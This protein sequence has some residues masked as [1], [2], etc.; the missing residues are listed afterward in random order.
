MKR[1]PSCAAILFLS[2]VWKIAIPPD[3]QNDLKEAL[4]EFFERNHF[5]VVVTDGVVNYTPIIQA[6]KPRA[7]YKSPD[8]L[9]AD[10]SGTSFD[11]SL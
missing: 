4:V 9:P 11:F 3:V 1:L 5:N 7:I 6:N 8:L 10:R 2:I